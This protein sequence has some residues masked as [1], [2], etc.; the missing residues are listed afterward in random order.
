MKLLCVSITCLF[1][2]GCIEPI[3][4]DK[5][6]KQEFDQVLAVMEKQREILEDQELALIEEGSQYD[7]EGDIDYQYEQS[8]QNLKDSNKVHC[9]KGFVTID[10]WKFIEDH[11]KFWNDETVKEKRELY[12]GLSEIYRDSKNCERT[13]S[14][15]PKELYPNLADASEVHP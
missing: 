4:Q 8:V 10:T 2:V 5:M 12:E 15:L 14:Y 3:N 13:K 1:L 9:E 6:T 7:A 11:S